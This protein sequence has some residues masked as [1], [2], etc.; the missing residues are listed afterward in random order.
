[1]QKCV[2]DISLTNS[3]TMQ[4]DHILHA[5]MLDILFENKNKAYGAY[6]LRR[7]YNKR[8]YAA[9]GGTLGVVLLFS[10]TTLFAGDKKKGNV[11][12]ETIVIELAKVEEPKPKEKIKIPESPAPARSAPQLPQLRVIP[13][14]PPRIVEDDKAI[15][16]PVP[17]VKELDKA[18][19]GNVALDGADAGIDAPLAPSTGG[20]KGLG[21][22]GGKGM[23]IDADDNKPV[24][25]VQIEARFP[26]GPDAWRRFLEKNLNTET[27]IE[28]GAAPARYTVIVSFIVDKEGNIS[29]VKAENDPG[30][31]TAAEAIRVIKRG[32]KW[33]PAVQNGRNVVYRQRQSIT[34]EVSEG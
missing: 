19:I 24:V 12:P 27:P 10:L 8:L 33:Q 13:N 29:E 16:N 6:A 26:G 18:V 9:L 14:T 22:P 4:A 1:M 31:G 23:G 34:F 25:I 21:V 17:D 20:G 15:D 28:N 11:A 32:P 30:Y 3:E 7:N 5:D 2:C